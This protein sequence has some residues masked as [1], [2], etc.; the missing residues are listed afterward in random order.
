MATW[1]EVE[2]AVPE[3]ADAVR[4]CFEATKHQVV[5][6]LR[7]DGAPRVSGTEVDFSGDELQLGSMPGAV[8][9]ATYSATVALRSTRTPVTVQ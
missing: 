8:K 6:T 7:K 5:A 9:A 4:A 1:R 3:L 2:T